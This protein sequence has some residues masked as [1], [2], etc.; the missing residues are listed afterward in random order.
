MNEILFTIMTGGTSLHLRTLMVLQ[1][2]RWRSKGHQ[3][4][5]T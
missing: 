5:E 1:Y 2:W 4:N 3:I